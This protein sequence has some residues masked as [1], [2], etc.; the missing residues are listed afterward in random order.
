MLNTYTAVVERAQPVVGRHFTEPYEAGWAQEAVVFV[1]VRDGLGADGELRAW[2]QVSPDGIEWVDHGAAL[3]T[4][5][6]GTSLGAIPVQNFG[7]WIR[8]G[9][10]CSDPEATVRVSV[11]VSLKG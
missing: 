9:L 7:D 5:L 10:A 11:Y 8:V 6:R 1:K 3:P 4:P 2:I